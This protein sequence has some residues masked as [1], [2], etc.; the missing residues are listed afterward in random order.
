MSECKHN[1]IRKAT[2]TWECSK[3]YQ[4]IIPLLMLFTVKFGELFL[5]KG[6]NAYKTYKGK[7]YRELK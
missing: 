5:E 3:C 1:H 7:I 4:T 6:Y 2:Y